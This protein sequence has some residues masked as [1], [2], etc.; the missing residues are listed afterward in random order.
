MQCIYH[1]GSVAM[2]IPLWKRWCS[3]NWSRWWERWGGPCCGR[4]A[5]CPGSGSAS[6]SPPIEK[7]HIA[8]PLQYSEGETPVYGGQRKVLREGYL[9]GQESNKNGSCFNLG[10]GILVSVAPLAKSNPENGWIETSW[11]PNHLPNTLLDTLPEQ[12]V[13]AAQSMISWWTNLCEFT[14]EPELLIILRIFPNY[15]YAASGA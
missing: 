9:R 14:T 10:E 1:C 15:F 13:R 4:K 11:N 12:D 3:L 5:A 7:D 6:C 2:H 8:E